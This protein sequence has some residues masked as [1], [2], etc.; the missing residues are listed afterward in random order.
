MPKE[1]VINLRISEAQRAA[2]DEAARVLGVSLSE[3]VRRYG[4][5][6]GVA[7]GTRSLQATPAP[8]AA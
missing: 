6:K 8:D 2:L 5:E 3:V 7:I 4:V 1:A